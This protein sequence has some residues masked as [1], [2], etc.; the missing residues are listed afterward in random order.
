ML[1]GQA[2]EKKQ[3]IK[4]G[5]LDKYGRPPKAAATPAPSAP[6]TPAPMAVDE[7][8]KKV[9]TVCEDA[10][11]SQLI[12]TCD[13]LLA[14]PM[15]NFY[16]RKHEA[17]TG[18]EAEKTPKK[19]KKKK[20]EADAETPAEE[21]KKKSK[22]ADAEGESPSTEKKKKKKEKKEKQDKVRL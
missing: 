2:L 21:K 16:Q 14:P 6:A 1:T 17:E 10:L 5:K 13:Y 18:S 22:D 15:S 8:A 9:C 20:K 12:I 19:D 4:E 7:E 3:L 11:L